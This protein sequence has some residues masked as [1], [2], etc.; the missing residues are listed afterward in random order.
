MGGA[1]GAE[2]VYALRND[3]TLANLALDYIGDAGQTKRR[4]YQRRLPENPNKDYYYIIRETSPAESLLVEY[5]FIDN[6]KDAQKLQ[7]NITSYAE[8]VVKAIAEYTNTPYTKEQTTDSFYV[9]KKGDTIYKVSRQFNIPV[10]EIKRIN[11]LNSDLLSIGQILYLQE[12]LTSD[13]YK[14]YTV[15]RGDSLWS[16]ARENNTTVNDIKNLN[17]LTSDNLIVGQQILI[18]LSISDSDEMGPTIPTSPTGPIST[19]S[20]DN[21]IIYEVRKGDSLWKI[22]NNNNTTVDE[23]IKLNNLDNLTLQIGEKI[24]IPITEEEKPITVYV[25]KSG[26]T[27]WS[28]AKAN[29]TDVNTLK[30]IN[31]LKS[32]L[33]SLG[34]EIIIPQ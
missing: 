27:L 4:V 26:D 9:V 15:K 16:I 13:N 11:N 22:A 10:A 14:T 23:L 20:V 8:G 7:N 2:I 33:L 24:K 19:P 31:N 6:S 25:V 32:N 30:Q 1:E 5:G 34:Q 21:Y 17:G 12:N 3:S 28:I 18:P 29:N